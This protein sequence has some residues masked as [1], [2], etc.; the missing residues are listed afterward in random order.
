MGL[1]FGRNNQYGFYCS[2]DHKDTDNISREQLATLLELIPQEKM[3]VA[4]NAAGFELPVLYKAY[5]EQWKSN[6]WRGF[7]PNMVDSRI[8]ASY[9][10]ENQQSHGLKQLTKLLIGYEQTSY[11]E[12][13]Q[14]RKMNEMT[15]AETLSY[16]LDDVYT[17][18]GLWNFTTIMQIEDTLD[19]FMRIEQYP[20]YLSALS[21]VNVGLDQPRPLARVEAEGRGRVCRVFQ[22]IER[23]P[24]QA[25][26]ER[27]PMSPFHRDADPGTGQGSGPDHPRATAGDG[28]ADHLQD[29]NL[30]RRNRPPGLGSARH[31]HPGQQPVDQRLGSTSV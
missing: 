6:G 3:T 2:V 8:A 12:V 14:G 20:M 18:A 15:A 21:F 29:G 13:T 22:D 19:A 27:H 5:G 30:D 26:V 17:A 25:G 10:D 7:F 31:V 9:W 23:V 28:G 4:H 24:D 16:G 1:T 11:D